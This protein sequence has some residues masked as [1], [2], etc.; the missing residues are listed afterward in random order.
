MNSLFRNIKENNSLDAIEESDDENDFENENDAKYVFL[1]RSYKM[2]CLFNSRFK[3][4]IPVSLIA[5]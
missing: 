3:K 5:N 1:N 4:W 2:N